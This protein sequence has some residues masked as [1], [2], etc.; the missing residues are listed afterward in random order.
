[1]KK[2]SVRYFS[3]LMTC[4]VMIAVP[5]FSQTNDAPGPNFEIATIKP[6]P[7]HQGAIPSFRISGVR[8]DCLQSLMSLIA[9]AYNMK[10]YQIAGPD[11]L[12]SSRFEIHAI[13]PE[14]ISRNKMPEMLQTLLENRFGL[15][16]HSEQR[17]QPAWELVVA[18]GGVK[19]KKAM[20]GDEITTAGDP[21]KDPGK[22]KEKSL[23]SWN[24]PDGR[25][26]LFSKSGKD[27]IMT[28][29]KSGE[30]RTSMDKDML[31]VELPKVTMTAFAEEMLSQYLLC[32]IQ[33]LNNTGVK[34]SYQIIMEF[35]SRELAQDLSQCRQ[36]SQSAVGN[37]PFGEATGT[38]NDLSNGVIFRAVQKLGLKLK[39]RK[40]QSTMLI[41]DH[42][43]KEPTEN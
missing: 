2:C 14:G 40:I 34:G 21:D 37:T 30:I 8:V 26:L 20:E 43:E 11:W 22:I 13:I 6:F 1:M 23:G 29:G 19:L 27:S 42:I 35:P 10:E 15:R 32:G 3:S 5:T 25:N 18:K 12:R 36:S 38:S 31:R 41:I 33:V 39:T 17:L 28:G 16:T 24:A 4:I 9:A 7:A